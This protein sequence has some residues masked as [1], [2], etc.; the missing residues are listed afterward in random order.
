MPRHLRYQPSPWTTHLIT[1]R[2]T[3]GKGLLSPTPALNSLIAGCLA[4]ALELCE[5]LERGLTG[6]L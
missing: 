4:R 2:C 1:S 6:G 5:P 3:E